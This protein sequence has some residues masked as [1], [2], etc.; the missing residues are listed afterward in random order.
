MSNKSKIV[1]MGT[2]QFA[3]DHLHA[4]ID[5]SDLFE[6]KAVY[7]RPDKPKGRS[8]NLV[9]S[10]VKELALK[11]NLPVIQVQNF[12]NESDVNYLENL[13]PDIIVIVA[14]GMI[15]PQ[16][17]LSIPAYGAINIHASILPKY[18]GASPI[19]YALL[20]GDSVTG[21]TSFLLDAGIDTGNILLQKEIPITL[22]DDY[23]SLINKLSVIG[24][25]CL[26]QTLDKIIISH[27]AYRGN[28][29]CSTNLSSVPKIKKEQSCI[30]IFDP[31]IK[32]HNQIRA[33]N[34]WPVCSFKAIVSKVETDLKI[35][36]SIPIEVCSLC[37]N[38]SPGD[39]SIFNNKSLHI[40]T[41][42]GCVDVLEVQIQGKKRM[43]INVFLN[44]QK[45]EKII[46]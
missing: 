1:F 8:Q 29:Q 42:S 4:I 45:I 17:I 10:E 34:Y 2:P 18:R 19:Q 13:K 16:K 20:N 9:F 33:L 32:I 40:K 27:F 41:G 22:T 11:H 43:P 6:I 23:E 26:M 15:L 35:Y 46:F 39:V 37:K 5:K 30:N 7:T 21:V 44:G 31:A 24:I 25:E 3:A 12:K 28:S 36:K 14:F 38:S